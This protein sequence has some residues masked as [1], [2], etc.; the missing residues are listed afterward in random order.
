MRRCS[1]PGIDEVKQQSVTGLPLPEAAKPIITTALG[2][3]GTARHFQ[4]CRVFGV[5]AID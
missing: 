5:I 1:R 3:L 4:Q 2:A